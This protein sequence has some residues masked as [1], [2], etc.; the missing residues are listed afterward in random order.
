[1]LPRLNV[2]VLSVRF[3]LYLD[4][5]S[6]Y[7]TQKLMIATAMLCADILM[8]NWHATMHCAVWC[9]YV[10]RLYEKPTIDLVLTVGLHSM[11]HTCG[12]IHTS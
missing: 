11:F 12:H 5:V 2:L 4:E 8:S 10:M 6:G 9:I 3:D 7:Q 1:M